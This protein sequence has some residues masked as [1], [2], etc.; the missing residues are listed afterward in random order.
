MIRSFAVGCEHLKWKKKTNKRNTTE[1]VSTRRQILCSMQFPL[2]GSSRKERR[3][4]AMLSDP[5]IAGGS[6]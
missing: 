3:L 5:P 1:T 6:P 4:S 2:A